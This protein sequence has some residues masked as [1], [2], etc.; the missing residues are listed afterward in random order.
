MTVDELLV[1]ENNA[2]IAAAR[3]RCGNQRGA[4]RRHQ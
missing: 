3:T 4:A 2:S 1:R